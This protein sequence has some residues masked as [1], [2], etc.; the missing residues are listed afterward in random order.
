MRDVVE[1]GRNLGHVDRDYTK[2]NP[3]DEPGKE[4]AGGETAGKKA[5]RG[6]VAEGESRAEQEAER[7]HHQVL[8]RPRDIAARAAHTP[9]T[10][11]PDAPQPHQREWG[12][13]E[14]DRIL[15][16]GGVGG[17]KPVIPGP[18]KTHSAQDG[19]QRGETE[20]RDGEARPAKCED[21]E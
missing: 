18:E 5:E 8:P 2:K 7:G 17:T 1:P 12:T 16:G 14:S 10:H 21:C 9:L 13:R 20:G 11:P 15:P 4:G 6:G 3:T 19:Q